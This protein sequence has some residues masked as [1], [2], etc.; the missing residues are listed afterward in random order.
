MGMD[1]ERLG[2]ARRQGMTWAGFKVAEFSGQDVAN[3]FYN[4]KD[5]NS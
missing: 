2:V 5:P 3:C 4:Q 1:V